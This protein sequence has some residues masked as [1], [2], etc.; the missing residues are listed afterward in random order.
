[1]NLNAIENYKI[2]K[3]LE[4]PINASRNKVIIVVAN[5]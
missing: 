3:G 2:N 5:L 4:N 1:M